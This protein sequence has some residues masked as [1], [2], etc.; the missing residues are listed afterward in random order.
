MMGEH[1]SVGLFLAEL[2]VMQWRS[3]YDTLIVEQSA[4][5]ENE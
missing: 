2:L 5:I 3:R 4:T 1:S